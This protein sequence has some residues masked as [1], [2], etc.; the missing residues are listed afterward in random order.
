MPLAQVPFLGTPRLG[1]P[2]TD[3][4]AALF[5][6]AFVT[7]PLQGDPVVPGVL[8]DSPVPHPGFPG[9]PLEKLE[10]I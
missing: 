3:P 1:L 9:H 5:A 7:E 2:I 4:A 8:A 6:P 10:Q